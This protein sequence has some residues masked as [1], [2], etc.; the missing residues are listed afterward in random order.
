[1]Q[2]GRR[3]FDS[4]V[5]TRAERYEIQVDDGCAHEAERVPAR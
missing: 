5:L 3:D 4:S 1:L 2:R